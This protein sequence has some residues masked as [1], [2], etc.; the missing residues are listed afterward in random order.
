MIV[1]LNRLVGDAALVVAYSN[2]KCVLT[3][4]ESDIIRIIIKFFVIFRPH[5]IGSLND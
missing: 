1:D 5:F 3:P 2:M 4:A